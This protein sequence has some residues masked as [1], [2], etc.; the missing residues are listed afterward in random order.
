MK[1]CPVCNSVWKS[2]KPFFQWN[3]FIRFVK[4]KA[5]QVIVHNDWNHPNP[6][7]RGSQKQELPDCASFRELCMYEPFFKGEKKRRIIVIDED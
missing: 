3:T 1:Y 4:D 2:P 7:E 6:L 5:F